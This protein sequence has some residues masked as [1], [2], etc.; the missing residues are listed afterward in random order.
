LLKRLFRIAILITQ[1]S[2]LVQPPF[3]F[4]GQFAVGDPA[5]IRSGRAGAE[6][7]PP[8]SGLKVLLADDNALNRR[9]ALDLLT[10]QGYTAVAVENGAQALE[11]VKRELFDLVLMDVQM[12]IMD[13]ITAT[14]AIR[15]PGSGALDPSVPIVALTAH[16]LKGDRER[17]LA[18]GMNDYIPK[19]IKIDTF[20]STVAEVVS[21]DRASHP[22]REDAPEGG[23]GNPGPAGADCVNREK[24]GNSCDAFDREGALDMLG[25]RADLLGRMDAIFVRDT[26]GELAELGQSI[27]AGDWEN[28]MRLAHSIKGSARTVGV[29]RAGAQAEQVEFFC[30]QKDAASAAREYK[31]LESEAFSALEFLKQAAGRK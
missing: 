19:P 10:E 7:A 20:Y 31:T 29:R 13:G 30:R 23:I 1:R 14:R 12:P 28:A 4:I 18:A 24:G 8:L 21:R 5:A 2:Y 27:K 6:P 11:A 16:A 3:F 9:L 22:A 26:P 17:F 15:D 25:G